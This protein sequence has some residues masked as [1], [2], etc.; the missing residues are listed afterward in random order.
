M[1]YRSSEEEDISVNYEEKNSE[2]ILFSLLNVKHTKYKK[3]FIH[4]VNPKI[5]EGT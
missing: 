5:S 4:K 3:Y 2:K 1:N